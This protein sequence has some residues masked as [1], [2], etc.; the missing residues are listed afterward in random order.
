LRILIDADGNLAN[1]GHRGELVFERAYN[2]AGAAPTDTW[3]AEDVLGGYNEGNGAKLWSFGAGMPNIQ[4]G[5]NNSHS[6]WV[7]GLGTISG[8]S[9]ILGFSMGVGSGWGLFAGAV[10]NL[11]IGL[12]GVETTYNI[13]VP[14]TLIPM[15]QPIAMAAA[16][17]LGLT[18]VSRR[19]VIR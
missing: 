3:V 12:N 7:A 16:G 2:V 17:F 5:H 9:A 6:V 14:A 19:R 4:H 11:T 15:Q 8:S 18:L 13:E 10:D 1:L